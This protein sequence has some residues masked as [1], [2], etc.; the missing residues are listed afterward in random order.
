MNTIPTVTCFI[1]IWALSSPRKIGRRTRSNSTNSR[2]QL[3]P[4]YALAHDNLAETLLHIDRPQE[5]I[6]HYQEALRLEPTMAAAHHNLANALLN[7]GRVPE[8]IEHYKKALDLNPS[9]ADAHFNYALMLAGMKQLDESI[10]QFQEGLQFDPENAQA[11]FAL[12]NVFRSAGRAQE[13][14]EEYQQALNLRPDYPEAETNL[15]ALRSGDTGPGLS[16]QNVEQAS[17]A[18]AQPPRSTISP[19]PSSTRK[20]LNRP[21]KISSACWR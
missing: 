7:T 17:A 12:G 9:L 13:A 6:V 14:M 3:K 21:R 11:H 20:S 16:S 18:P 10:E 15:L 4:D 1:T 8:A 2:L 5:A 19:S